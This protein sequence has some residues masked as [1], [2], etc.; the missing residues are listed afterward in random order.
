MIKLTVIFALV[1]TY[2]FAATTSTGNFY[3]PRNNTCRTVS[4]N[5]AT[6]IQAS[7]SNCLTF[8]WSDYQ[9]YS[10]SYTNITDHAT[11]RNMALYMATLGIAGSFSSNVS[12]SLSYACP[13]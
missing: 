3:I 1:A 2:A 7:K 4:A 9:K 10:T 8:S 13:P 5:S 11:G 6:A 12:S